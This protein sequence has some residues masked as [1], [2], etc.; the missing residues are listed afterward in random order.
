MTPSDLKSIPNF[1]AGRKDFGEVTFLQAVDISDIPLDQLLG[2]AIVFSDR[3]V[4]IYPEEYSGDHA[5]EGEGLNVPAEVSLEDAWKRDKN[6]QE[7]VTDV[8]SSGHAGHLKRL[9]G[10]DGT[11]FV[12]FTDEGV[13][14]FRVEHFSGYGVDSSDDEA[15]APS[16][17]EESATGSD[18]SEEE[19]EEDDDDD[20][21]VMPP[22]KGL[23]DDEDRDSGLEDEG[24]YE[25]D[26]DSRSSREGGSSGSDSLGPANNG[27]R[28][29]SSSPPPYDMPVDPSIGMAGLRKLKEM[30]ESFFG[31]KVRSG[32]NDDA[33]Y[34]LGFGEKQKLGKM[35]RLLEGRRQED[36]GVAEGEKVERDNRAVTVCYSF[37]LVRPGCWFS[38]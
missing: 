8:K 3:S 28:S 22:T 12:S 29:R 1:T 15:G 16:A 14:M 10:K 37:F 7:R 32:S 4:Q 26:E 6:T 18:R 35:K 2:G 24:M 11:E 34:G 21:D 19:E 27:S 5:P 30:Q 23:R 20:D 36:F 17:S 33:V 13:W 9:K 38:G 31:E 25:E